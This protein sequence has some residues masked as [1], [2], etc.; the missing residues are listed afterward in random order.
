MSDPKVR[1]RVRTAVARE[2]SD[3]RARGLTVSPASVTVCYVLADRVDVIDATGD[4]V[5]LLPQLAARLLEE[6][7]AANLLPDKPLDAGDDV[8]SQLAAQ[9]T[10]DAPP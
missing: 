4:D 5:Y 6:R 1:G 8:W 10:G 2:I 3:A 7:K 9:L